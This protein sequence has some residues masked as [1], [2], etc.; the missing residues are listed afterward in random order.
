[1]TRSLIKEREAVSLSVER[2]RDLVNEP[3]SRAN[4]DFIVE[5]FQRTAQSS[6]LEIEIL[7]RGDLKK[8]GFAGIAAVGEASPHE[9]ALIRL[10]YIPAGGYTKTAALVG[11][12]ITFDSGGLSLK[13][14]A[15]M[16]E[17]K[18]DMAGAAAVLGVIEAASKLRLPVRIDAFAAVAENMPGQY[19]YKPGDILVFNNGKSV[20]ILNTDAEG[21]LLLAD[22]LIMATGKKPDLI[23][24]LSTLTGSVAHALGDGMAAV[25]SRSDKLAASLMKAGQNTGERLCRLPLLEDYKESIKSKT[26]D[27]KN[28]SYGTAHGIKAGL[29]LNEFTKGIPFAH[30]DIAG[31]AFLSKPNACCLREGATGFGVRLLLDFLKTL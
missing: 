27:L 15:S 8:R 7:R 28:N 26:A 12:G 31:T 5:E 19:A 21:R 29:F 3:P 17:M 25:M 16:Q 9:P 18:S 4:P 14:A 23:V 24:E 6:S 22:A 13:T 11:K 20:E 10:S 1:L 30:I 2:T